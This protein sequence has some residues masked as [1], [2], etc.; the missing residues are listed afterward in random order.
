[1]LPFVINSKLNSKSPALKAL[2]S[3]QK[4]SLTLKKTSPRPQILARGIRIGKAT[5]VLVPRRNSVGTQDNWEHPTLAKIPFEGNIEEENLAQS[6][7][8]DP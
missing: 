4:V 5:E 7:N 8:H 6:H 2:N 3:I 1:M